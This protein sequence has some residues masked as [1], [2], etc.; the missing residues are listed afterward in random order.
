MKFREGYFPLKGL[1][2]KRTG[3]N[4]IIHVHIITFNPAEG[5][6]VRSSSRVKWSSVTMLVAVQWLIDQKLQSS[7]ES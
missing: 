1:K 3:Y 7:H 6:A 4:G 2:K 5:R